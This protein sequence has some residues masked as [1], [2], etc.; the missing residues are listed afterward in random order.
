MIIWKE[1]TCVCC[2]ASVPEGMM[3]CWI[4]E[5]GDEAR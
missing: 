2:G 4:C 3:V 5:H 1:D